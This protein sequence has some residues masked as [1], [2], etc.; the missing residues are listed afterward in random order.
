MKSGRKRKNSNHNLDRRDF[1]II[2]PTYRRELKHLGYRK[3]KLD[4]PCSV[5]I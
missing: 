1:S 4:T 5:K 3:V 2:R